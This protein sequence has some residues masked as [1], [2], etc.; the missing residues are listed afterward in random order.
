MS[1]TTMT[2]RAVEF[3]VLVALFLGWILLLAAAGTAHASDEHVLIRFAD[4]PGRAEV[5]LVQRHGG[6]VKYHYTLVPAM[7]ASLPPEAVEKL[8]LHPGVL[9]VEADGVVHA[10]AE[11]D[12]SWG[13]GHID[14]FAVHDESQTGAQVRVAVIDSGIDPTHEDLAVAGGYNFVG[15]NADLFDDNGHGTHVAGI[16]AA[17]WN[18]IGVVGV[19]PDAELYGLKVLSAEGSGRWSDIIAALEWSVENDIDVTNNSYGADGNPGGTVREAFEAAE[20]EGVLHIAA[21]GNSGSPSGRGNSILYPARFESVVAVGATDRDDQRARWSSTGPALELMAPGVGIRSTLPGDAYTTYSGTSMASPHAAGVAAL[22]IAEGVADEN[23]NG[24]IND[25]V[26]DRLRDTAVDLG[27]EGWNPQY[28]HGRVDAWAAVFADGSGSEPAPDPEDPEGIL[29]AEV[30]SDREVYR[31]G[32]RARLIVEV[33]DEA[34]YAVEGAGVDLD[35]LTPTGRQFRSQ[36]RTG[37]DG[38]AHFTHRINSRRDGPGT[39]LVDA[40]AE[41]TGYEEDTASTTFQVE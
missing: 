31:H 14:A 7:A 28:G 32:D 5:A 15:G 39:Y 25:E 38:R 26:R 1:M 40:V 10:I 22:I 3:R 20:Q 19:A 8:S 13:V 29:V 35:I 18:G 17:L 12:D 11:R 2:I 23:G 36:E 41:L 9:R 30:W 6:T 37:S 24:R 27:S 34:G 21:A 16:T 4:S 33:T